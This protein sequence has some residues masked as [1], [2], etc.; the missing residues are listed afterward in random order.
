MRK[1]RKGLTVSF[2]GSVYE[3]VKVAFKRDRLWLRPLD[4]KY[5]PQRLKTGEFKFDAERDVV[6]P[7]RE[8]SRRMVQ[9]WDRARAA[10]NIA[11]R[12]ATKSVRIETYGHIFYR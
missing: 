6:L 4:T 5:V 2:R 3:V 9:A 10:A 12:Q 8:V 1:A 11:Y 7:V